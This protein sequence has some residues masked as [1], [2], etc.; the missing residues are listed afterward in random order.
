MTQTTTKIRSLIKFIVFICLSFLLL[1]AFLF[2]SLTKSKSGY[3]DYGINTPKYILRGAKDF[4]SFDYSKYSVTQYE[5]VSIPSIPSSIHLSGWLIKSQLQ[6]PS[7]ILVHG[8]DESKANPKLLVIAGILAKKNINVLM[9]D[10][11]NHG[12]STI[13]NGRITLGSKEYLDIL[14][15]KKWLIRQNFSPDKIG[16]MGLSLGATT[17][18]IAFSEDPDFRFLIL[19]SPFSDSIAMIESEIN[20]RN[21]P[22]VFIAPSLWIGK[23]FFN[24][25][26]MEKSPME[27]IHQLIDRPILLMHSKNDPL[28]PFHHSK[29]IKKGITFNPYLSTYFTNN[30]GHNTAIFSDPNQYE[31][32]LVEFIKNNT[33]SFSNK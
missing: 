17:S 10:L 23:H 1:S 2:H 26:L 19:D 22:N 4:P 27:S 9:I 20:K 18:L 5:N 31:K 15:A 30:K 11:R 7:V 13:T 28:I 33:P 25:D 21:I 6:N 3:G 8:K 14:S 16:I 29:S 24:T 12:K 32:K